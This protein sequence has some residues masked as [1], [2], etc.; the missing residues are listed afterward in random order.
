MVPGVVGGRC[1]A[2]KEKNTLLGQ[3][4]Q[5]SHNTLRDKHSHLDLGKSHKRAQALMK[6]NNSSSGFE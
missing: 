3:V 4:S 6:E 5:L 1:L 2:Q